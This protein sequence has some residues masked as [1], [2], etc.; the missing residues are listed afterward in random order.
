MAPFLACR[1]IRF[2]LKHGVCQDSVFGFVLYASVL[3][4]QCGLVVDV[5]EVC[6]VGKVAMSLLKRFDS[7]E[8]VPKVN[9]AYYG[10][11]AVHTLPLQTC[12]YHLRKGFEG[13]HISRV[14]NSICKVI[15]FIL[16]VC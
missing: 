14:S 8:I 1:I 7:P 4:Q 15:A 10:F 12:A 5:R 3:C 13:K 2:S 6:R 9:F 16:F 11:V